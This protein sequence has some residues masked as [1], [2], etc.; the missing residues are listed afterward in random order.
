MT[1]TAAPPSSWHIWMAACRPRTLPAA[2]APVVIGAALAF[3][4]GVFTASSALL[5]LIGALLLQVAANLANDYYDAQKGADGPDRLGP[6]RATASGLVTP[7]EM[8]RAFILVLFMATVI[9]AEL[10]RRGGMP[11]FVIGIASLVC[12]VLYT[13]GPR[14]LGYLGLGEVFVFIFFGPVAVAGTYWVQALN[15]GP[16][17]VA[18]GIAPGLLS[19]AVLL[20]NNLRDVDTDRR[21]GKRT[22][23]V[24]FGRPFARALYLLCVVGAGLSLF[25]LVPRF[26]LSSLVALF[27]VVPGLVLFQKIRREEG[28]AL[29]P[30]LGETARLLVV[31]A[32]LL[33]LALV[34]R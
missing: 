2:A 8:K 31:H 10:I 15:V 11:I 17:V 25:A 20:V 30:R 21:A 16:S 9:G 18:A 33:S 28:R 4:D 14:P 27:T 19:A 3:H 7:A 5:A 1:T 26:G 13:G 34:V 23:A 6:V 29:N 24:R 32:V 22:L 12:A